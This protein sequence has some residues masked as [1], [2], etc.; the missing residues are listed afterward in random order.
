MTEKLKA[1][2]C[3]AKMLADGCSNALCRAV[4]PDGC[5]AT[6][7]DTFYIRE[8]HGA[9]PRYVFASDSSGIP[10]TRTIETA[11]TDEKR[12]AALEEIHCALDNAYHWSK[13][14]ERSDIFLSA[15]QCVKE[16]K[17]K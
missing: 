7:P 5:K 8:G 11:V 14:H 10:Y 6:M 17:L 9:E 15:I 13:S 16:L 12:K 2:P 3:G 4:Y 1:C